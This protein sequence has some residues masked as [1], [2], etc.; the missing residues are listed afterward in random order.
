[1]FFRSDDTVSTPVLVQD[2]IVVA[3]FIMTYS[4]TAVISSSLL[5]FQSTIII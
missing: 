5:E 1:M 3:R 4:A 2:I